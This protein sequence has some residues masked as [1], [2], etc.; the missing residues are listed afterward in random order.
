VILGVIP[1]RGGSKGLPGK[2]V[3]LLGGIP[4]IAHSIRAARGSRRLDDV[5]VSTDDP[6]IADAAREAG[7]RVPSLRPAEL[8]TDRIP[9]WPA[10]RHAVTQWEA[11]GGGR[12][13]VAVLLQP[14]S[15][16]RTSADI[17]A[18]VSRLLD[19][20]AEMCVSVVR[21]HDSPYFNM[22]EITPDATP[23]ARACSPLMRDASRRQDA[24]AVYALNGAVYAVR[25]DVL[26]TLENQFRLERLVV[27]E[28]ARERSV[29]IDTLEDFELAE[30]LLGRA[31]ATLG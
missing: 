14:T 22:V 12:V 5:V 2:N 27:S 8:A 7:A 16:L 10:V 4:L 15:P 24:P 20:D 3:K 29:D 28:M 25:R 23:F 31:V 1:A 30:W 21:P 17:D 6:A 18:C 26:E 19:E 11:G 9:V 13:D